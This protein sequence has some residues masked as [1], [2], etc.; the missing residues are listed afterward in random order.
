M[1]NGN[2]RLRAQ[3]VAAAGDADASTNLGQVV[4]EAQAEAAKVERVTIR[5]FAVRFCGARD[6]LSQMVALGA[7]LFHGIARGE[8]LPAEKD[9]FVAGA[10]GYWLLNVAPAEWQEG[11][12]TM[13]TADAINITPERK[14][15]DEQTALDRLHRR[16]RKAGQDYAADRWR[17]F[18]NS[19]K[20]AAKD[21]QDRETL[22]DAGG[23]TIK[24]PERAPRE[25]NPHPSGRADELTKAL[26]N[27]GDKMAKKGWKGLDLTRLA[28]LTDD[29]AK[30]FEG[31][32]WTD[33]PKPE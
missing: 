20:G 33:A 27:L 29:I 11:N 6:N 9:E 8:P 22:Q 25:S 2:K 1:K 18:L 7:R 30:M 16:I 28:V 15:K 12:A 23:E 4:A 13:R 3:I 19:I 24:A 31:A 17:V 21:L 26:R 14:P 32:T 10:Q 5:E